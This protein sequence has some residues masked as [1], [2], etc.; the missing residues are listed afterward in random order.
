MNTA[1]LKFRESDHSYWLGSKQLISVTQLMKKHGLCTDYTFVKKTVLN[2]KA[3]RGSLIHEEIEKYIKTGETGFTD[4]L[5]SFISL[6]SE[7]KIK[8]AESEVTVHDELIAGT[9]DVV[10]RAEDGRILADVKTCVKLDK[11]AL[12][13]QLSLYEYLFKCQN[14]GAEI[15]RLYGIHLS[16]DG[17]K[18]VEV[19]R[20]PQEEID[21]LL[22]CE[23]NGE[24]FIPTTTALSIS[25]TEIAYM[26]DVERRISELKRQMEAY[27]KT[28]DEMKE[29]LKN[30][31][32]EQGVKSYEDDLLKI[33]YIEP[34]V[35][36]GVDA[37]N[38][39]ADKPEIYA[40]YKKVT[41]VKDG[42]KITLRKAQ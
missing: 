4:E 8:P 27:S 19:P 40:A 5:Y 33:T 37:A 12:S 2:A 34:Y 23:R 13:W 3:E 9:I 6:L 39:K 1:K 41:K 7:N 15:K 26:V 29:E 35:R 42:V 16:G 14:P 31:M 10:G 38:L 20:I 32:K 21:K 30:R 36:E 25:T 11:A 22:E 18:L 17:A 24:L 28:Y